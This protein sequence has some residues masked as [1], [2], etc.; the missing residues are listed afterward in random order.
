LEQFRPLFANRS[1]QWI[2]LQVGPAAAQI[3]LG[4][5]AL[6]ILDCAER[7][8][9]FKETAAL[10]AN[11]DLVIAV[12]TAV[13]HLAGAIGK[14]VWILLP[15]AAEWRWGLDAKSTLWWPSAVLFR[16]PRPGDWVSVIRAVEGALAG[17]C[18]A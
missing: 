2:S 5:A 10:V 13:A 6:P 4:E 3:G 15:F 14:P 1:V 12:D 17:L 11:L 8:V 9:D 16:Q 7:L 18:P